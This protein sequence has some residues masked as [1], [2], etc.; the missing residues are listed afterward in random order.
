MAGNRGSKDGT[1]STARFNNPSSLA[2]D[3]ATNIYVVDQSNYTIRKITAG[4]EVSTFAGSVGVWGSADGTTGTARFI[5]PESIAVDNLGNVYIGDYHTVRKITPTGVVSTLAGSD[6]IQGV[7]DGDGFSARFGTPYGLTVDSAGNIYI[8]DFGNNMV[9]KVTSDGVVNTLAGQGVNQ[10]NID[11]IGRA[12]RFN[13]P[14]GVAPDVA[15]N[16]YVA[17]ALNNSIR[18]VLPSGLVITLAGFGALAGAVDGNLN[19]A[20]FNSPRGIA[21]DGLGSVFIADTVNHTIREINLDGNVSTLAGLA[22][23]SGSADGNGSSARFNTPIGVAIDESST[24]YVADTGNH[25]I[26]KISTD[27]SVGTLAG[28]AG[29]QGLPMDLESPRDSPVR[30]L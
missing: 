28:A 23:N 8:G 2:I 13:Y 12:A 18:K 19:A 16:L 20:R 3:D 14:T 26:R 30:R 10:G 1:G 15:G 9:L 27:G 25:T 6:Y 17:D 11:D 21:V 29:I 7:V 22:R 4:G 5:A 24:I